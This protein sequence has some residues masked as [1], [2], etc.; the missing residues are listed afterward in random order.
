MKKIIITI[1]IMLMLLIASETTVYERQMGVVVNQISHK[2]YILNPG[3]HIVLPLIETDSIIDLNPHNVVV[4]TNVALAN[5]S[6][7]EISV[8]GQW[9]V[10]DAL[11]Y[12]LATSK[13]N[14]FDQLIANNIM[15]VINNRANTTNLFTLNQLNNL[16]LAPVSLTQLGVVI[17]SITINQINLAA[18]SSN[19]RGASD[20]NVQSQPDTALIESA[21]YTAQEI[22][23]QTGIEQAKMMEQI[24]NKDDKFFNYFRKLQVYKDSA[25]SK[26][27]MPSLD[28]LYK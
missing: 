15:Q 14:N 1:L 8:T 19:A 28:Q 2:N 24:Q 20:N 13:S 11:K 17:T 21:Y 7:I 10:V 26:Q 27:E 23:T 25:K 6:N 16:L 9:Q 18:L 22:K 5:K 4:T 12:Y 3:L